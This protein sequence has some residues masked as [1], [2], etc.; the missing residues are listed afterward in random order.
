MTDLLL[1]AAALPLQ[2]PARLSLR[3]GER[4]CG[5]TRYHVAACWWIAGVACAAYQIM[6]GD[7]G[8]SVRDIGMVFLACLWTFNMWVGGR[9]PEAALVT[10]DRSRFAFIGWLAA[11]MGVLFA[12]SAVPTLINWVAKGDAPMPGLFFMPGATVLEIPRDKGGG[13][14]FVQRTWAKV[15][16][17]LLRPAAVGA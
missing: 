15:R 6:F 17:A 2:V 7:K 8:P 4:F 16:E 13:L 5:A 9:R 14:P 10:G 11:F 3:V 12:T 1:R